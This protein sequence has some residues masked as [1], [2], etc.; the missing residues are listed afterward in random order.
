ALGLS[1]SA[2]SSSP[3][4]SSASSS[5]GSSSTTTL[6]FLVFLGFSGWPSSPSTSVFGATFEGFFDATFDTVFDSSTGGRGGSGL[7]GLVAGV[8]GF[9]SPPTTV[10]DLATFFGGIEVQLLPIPNLLFKPVESYKFRSNLAQ[11]YDL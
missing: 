6:G 8:G 4:S 10:D 5:T 7:R 1:S 11:E 9:S 2:S 3:S